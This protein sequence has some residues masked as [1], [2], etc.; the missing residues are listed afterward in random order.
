VGHAEETDEL[1]DLIRLCVAL[2]PAA[3]EAKDRWGCTPLPESLQATDRD[4]FVPFQIAA[5]NNAPLD[6][7][8]Y[9]VA[10]W[11]GGTRRATGSALGSEEQNSPA[12]ER[13][14]ESVA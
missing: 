10:K 3:L 5:A 11:P 2:W 13:K 8:F 14:R 1:M 6:L 12:R 4:G 7:L 9:L